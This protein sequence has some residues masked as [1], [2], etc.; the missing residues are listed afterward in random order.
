L[1]LLYAILEGASL[2]LGISRNEINGC[3]YYNDENESLIP[4]IMIY[5]VVP[6]GAGHVKKISRKIEEVLMGARRKVSG[7]CGC[8]E[9]TS[10]YGCLRNY[11]NQLFHEILSRGLPLN[12]LNNILPEPT[13][14]RDEKDYNI[15]FAAKKQL[16]NVN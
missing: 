4:S 11:S 7:A 1:S 12:Y 16:P 8:G 10:C 3:L 13:S 6:G 14:G 2:S 5:D 9:E 15:A